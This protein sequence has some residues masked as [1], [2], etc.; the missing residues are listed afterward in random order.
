MAIESYAKTFTVDRRSEKCMNNILHSKKV[1]V[2]NC[3]KTFTT[4]SKDEISKHFGNCKI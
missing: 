2:I 1:T 4:L 3:K